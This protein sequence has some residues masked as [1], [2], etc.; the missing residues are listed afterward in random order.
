[1]A[2]PLPHRMSTKAHEKIRISASPKTTSHPTKPSHYLKIVHSAA[3]PPPQLRVSPSIQLS[4][5]LS[6]MHKHI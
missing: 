1:M 5:Y 6:K 2:R 3:T 4:I